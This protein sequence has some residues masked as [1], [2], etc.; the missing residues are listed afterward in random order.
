MNTDE[1]AV[2]AR[3]DQIAGWD[4]HE[5]HM[6]YH[7]LLVESIRSDYG[8]QLAAYDA[9]PRWRRAFTRRPKPVLGGY[10]AMKP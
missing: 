1:A 7:R 4:D 3:A 9:L 6:R 2:L 8:R 5:L 10:A